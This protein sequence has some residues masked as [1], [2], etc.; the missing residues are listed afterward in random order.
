MNILTAWGV[1]PAGSAQGPGRPGAVRGLEDLPECGSAPHAPSSIFLLPP[2]IPPYSGDLVQAQASS[3]DDVQFQGSLV[4]GTV[5]LSMVVRAKTWRRLGSGRPSLVL[6]SD[7]LAAVLVGAV[8][9]ALP[10]HPLGQKKFPFMWMYASPRRVTLPQR[11]LS[12]VPRVSCGH[13]ILGQRDPIDDGSA[14]REIP[15]G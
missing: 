6:D 8:L 14:T 10:S 9:L 1:D 5:S 7:A 2:P 3:L 12:T 11:V 4:L 13:R 15:L